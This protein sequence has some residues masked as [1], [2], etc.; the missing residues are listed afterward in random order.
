MNNEEKKETTHF[1]GNKDKQLSLR[2][3]I[4]EEFEK[5]FFERVTITY[6][7]IYLLDIY[8]IPPHRGVGAQ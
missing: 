3:H 4:S 5:T 1:N 6:L 8:F 7:Y 2:N